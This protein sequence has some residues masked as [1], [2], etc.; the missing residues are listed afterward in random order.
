MTAGRVFRN[1]GAR[2]AALVGVGA[3]FVVGVDLARWLGPGLLLDPDPSWAA[4]RILLGLSLLAAAAAAAVLAAAGFRLFASSRLARERLEALPLSKGV[5]A[6]VAAAALLVGIAAR[7]VWIG[8]LPIPFL[9]DEVNLITPALAL[10][11]TPRDFADS[12]V[13]IPLGRKDPH[14]MI[15]VAYLEL[16]RSSLRAFGATVTGLRLPSVLGGALSLVTAGLLGRS[17]FPAGGGTAAVLVLA[18][19][20]WHVV[21]SLSGWH[22]VLLVPVVDVATLLLLS[23]R[24]RARGSWA[25]AAAGGA[26]MGIGPHVYLASW[27]AAGALAAFAVWPPVPA[28]GRGGRRLLAFAAGFVLV[29]SPLFLLKEGRRVPYFGRSSRHNLLSEIRYQ[30]SLLPAFAVV[31][32]A[33]P[34]PWLIPEPQARHDLPARPRLGWIVGA[35]VAVG[36]GRCLAS[37]REEVSGLLLLHACAAGAAAVAGGTAGHPNGFRFGYLTSPTALAAAAGMLALVGAV[38]PA[39]RRAAALA[40]L[41]LV[42]AGGALGIRDA[43]L[44]WPRRMATFDSFRGE[45][46]LIGQAAARW[47]RYGAVAVTPGLGRSDLTIETVR[48]YRLD[49]DGRSAGGAAAGRGTRVFRVMARG[50]EA[51]GPERVVERVRDPWG[52]EWAVVLASR[53]PAR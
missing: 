33:L 22:S 51:S 37:P 42:A 35:L 44:E 30:K 18:G 15:G 10:S 8:S 43:L 26:V 41:G 25:S 17:L 7:A 48:R 6:A 14:E 20:R 27:A 23:A 53:G 9:E 40:L 45:D 12:I 32:D 52:R 39:R 19:L 16:L 3:A 24:R 2:T 21:L 47:E 36:L 50:S 13:A 46:T 29:V 34:A 31:A 49:P 38:S 1:T 11:G 5:L 4:E 28:G